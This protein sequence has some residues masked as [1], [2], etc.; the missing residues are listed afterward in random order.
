[1]TPSDANRMVLAMA[2]SPYPG[3]TPPT[4]AERDFGTPEHLAR[5]KCLPTPFQ[6]FRYVTGSEHLHFGLWKDPLDPRPDAIYRAQAHMTERLMKLLPDPPARLI[7]VGC[8]IGGTSVMLAERGFTTE[9]YAPSQGLIDYASALAATHGVAERCTFGNL[10]F[11]EVPH[12]ATPFDVAFSQESL[13]YIHPLEATVRKLWEFVRPGGRLVVGDQVLR[14]PEGKGHVQFH[15]SEDIRAEAEKVGFRLFHH[16][17]VTAEAAPTVRRSLQFLEQHGE[18]IARLM[19]DVHPAIREDIR[20]CVDNGGQE[21][22]AYE[23]G[24][25]GYELFAWHRP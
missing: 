24:Q 20:V 25:L 18:K 2:T 7:D 1:V 6:I 13:Q 8:G 16:E 4:S 11:Q 22:T 12:P 15:L 9:G 17:D 14:V 19:E 10:P 23:Q 3:E 21:A 5:V